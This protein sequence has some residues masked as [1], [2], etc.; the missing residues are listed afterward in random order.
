MGDDNKIRVLIADDS[1]FMRKVLR[2]LLERDPQIEIAGE[3]RDGRDAVRLSE[4]LHPDVICMDLLMPHMDGLE[5]TEI[6]MSSK[7]RPI[8]VV[9]SE[10]KEG[11]EPA[12]RALELGAIDFV[13]KPSAG[14]DLDMAKVSGE[15]VRKVKLAAK[16][17]VVRTAARKVP[18]EQPPATATSPAVEE[19]APAPPPTSLKMPVV[20]IAASTGGPQTLMQVM[21][22]FPE[23]FSGAVL[24]VQHMPG[25]FTSVF[26]RQLAEVCT[27]RVKE[28]EPGEMMRPGIAYVCPGTHHMRVSITGRLLL[29]DGPRVNGYKPNAD[30]TLES[31][32]GFAGQFVVAVILT[33]MGGD[34]VNGAETVKSKGGYVIAQDEASS[35]VFGMN[36]EVIRRGVADHIVSPDGVYAAIAKRLLYLVGAAR[37][38]AL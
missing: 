23:T 28:A 30:I 29:E 36:G 17:H 19:P 4:E 26:S 11:A 12:V 32:A 20:V 33:G 8:L 24:I 9:S 16:V 18:K 3:A 10:T 22:Q 6:I 21:P 25:E 5:A 38:G 14:V 1:A 34:A 2:D 7:P 31:A 15:L 27:V 13:G 35:V 37:V